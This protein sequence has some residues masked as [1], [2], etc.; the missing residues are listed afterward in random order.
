M[1]AQLSGLSGFLVIGFGLFRGYFCL[2]KSDQRQFRAHFECTRCF[3]RTLVW[4]A[5]SF[6]WDGLIRGYFRMAPQIET[7]SHFDPSGCTLLLVLFCDQLC[8]DWPYSRPTLWSTLSRQTPEY[9]YSVFYSIKRR[10]RVERSS[11]LGE[12]CSSSDSAPD[13]G[14]TLLQ[15][16]STLEFRYGL[17]IKLTSCEKCSVLKICCNIKN[18]RNML[19]SALY[20]FMRLIWKI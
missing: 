14:I 10:P 1:V 4:S 18:Q 11:T 2:E 13:A 12:L 7:R 19:L 17:L 15:L 9:T 8:Q 16:W 6:F 3:K 5:D 20:N